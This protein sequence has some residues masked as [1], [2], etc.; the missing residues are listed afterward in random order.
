[1]KTMTKWCTGWCMGVAAAAAAFTMPAM[2]DSLHGEISVTDR[3][4]ET[5]QGNHFLHCCDV[6][7][8]AR[9]QGH[10]HCDGERLPDGEYYF[11]VTNSSGALLLSSDDIQQ[12]RIRI[13][14]GVIVEYLGVSGSCM[15]E[16]GDGASVELNPADISV[17]LMPFGASP[18]H[19][20]EH[21]VW[22]TRVCDYNP[23]DCHS[24]HGFLHNRSKTAHF[25][26]QPEMPGPPPPPP[27]CTIVINKY[28]DADAD[29]VN[30]GEQPLD[31]VR[32]DVCYTPPG[33]A[34]VCQ[35]IISGA[36][37]PGQVAIDIPPG[38]A[39]TICE[40]IPGTGEQG[41]TWMQTE[42]NENS[43][44]A[45][46]LNGQWCYCFTCPDAIDSVHTLAFGDVCTKP[47][48]GGKSIAYWRSNAGMKVLQHN[49]TV[50]RGKLTNFPFR[51][52]NGKPYHV[53]T[54]EFENAYGDFRHWMLSGSSNMACQLSSQFAALRLAV[55]FGHL[56]SHAKVLISDEA[57]AMLGT[58]DNAV[59]IT[60]LIKQ[61]RI[62]LGLHGLTSIAGPDHDYQGCLKAV[63][64]C[65][66]LNGMP[67]VCDEPC[68]IV[69]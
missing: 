51:C 48:S 22:L 38:S 47:A 63:M 62:T 27:V 11:Q 41:C 5:V 26:C 8:N 56:D 50:W 58:T 60:W 34:Q 69:Y 16:V 12:R 14:D 6:F 57:A 54:G 43:A 65:I 53:P 19:D 68:A 2:A 30:D 18:N 66:N 29:G 59:R 45:A 42:P 17:Q 20:G 7:L 46:L 35:T 24:V 33:C 61:A 40:E 36:D 21:K 23:E 1:M 15:H 10:S 52:S 39:V 9:P 67:F 32:F 25:K 28:F 55:L 37:C 31:G 4:G 64:R 49:E 44:D 3:E 13:S